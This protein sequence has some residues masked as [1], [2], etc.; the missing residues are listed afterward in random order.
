MYSIVSQIF[1][2]THAC[3][4]I[5]QAIFSFTSAVDS[6]PLFWSKMCRKLI[7]P[8]TVFQ[9]HLKDD[10]K[11]NRSGKLVF[12][13]VEM[14]IKSVFFKMVAVFGFQWQGMTSEVW[15]SS[16]FFKAFCMTSRT[17]VIHLFLHFLE[18]IHYFFDD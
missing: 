13:G 8:I 11:V 16:S 6:G 2:I 3:S 1:M 14:T 18:L 17:T 7:V 12:S 5:P 9:T 15:N 4:S 10:H